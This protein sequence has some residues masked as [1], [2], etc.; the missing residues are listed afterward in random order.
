MVVHFGLL[1]V[2]SGSL[3]GLIAK[4]LDSDLEISEFE[5]QSRCYI[6]FRTNTLGKGMISLIPPVM[7]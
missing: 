5:L 7:A 2:T 3:R 4:V 1:L 6:D